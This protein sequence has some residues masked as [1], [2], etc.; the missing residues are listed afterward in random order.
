MT[1]WCLRIACWITKAIN[2]HSEYVILIGF[3]R[4]IWLHELASMLRYAYIALF[5]LLCVVNEAKGDRFGD[6]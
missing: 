6:S 1:K 3:P 5:S 4:Q 2:T